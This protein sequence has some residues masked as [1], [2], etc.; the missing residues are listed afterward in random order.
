M[1]DKNSQ[2]AINKIFMAIGGTVLTLMTDKDLLEEADTLSGKN[3]EL[4]E[5]GM[6]SLDEAEVTEVVTSLS[7]NMLAYLLVRKELKNR[8]L[9]G[10]DV[11]Q[12]AEP[13]TEDEEFADIVSLVFGNE[14][15]EGLRKFLNGGGL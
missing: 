15:P 9:G 1:D 12:G 3:K 7:G 10:E 2:E 13:K 14:I 4:F 6:T 8:N 5:T 11:P